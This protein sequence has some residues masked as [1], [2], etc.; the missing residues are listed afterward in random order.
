MKYFSVRH[1]NKIYCWEKAT[2]QTRINKNA[3][4]IVTRH[5][6]EVR[7]HL[8]FWKKNKRSS[9]AMRKKKKLFGPFLKRKQKVLPCQ[10]YA[11]T[12]AN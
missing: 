8:S 4:K 1:C 3:L 6:E 7:T 11:Q 10:N 5:L 9:Y 12:K 2:A